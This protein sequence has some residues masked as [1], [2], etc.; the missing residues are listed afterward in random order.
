MSNHNPTNWTD[1]ILSLAME[2]AFG[3]CP[4]R[5]AMVAK[6]IGLSD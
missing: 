2:V 6:A 3:T 4:I 5:E 1:Y